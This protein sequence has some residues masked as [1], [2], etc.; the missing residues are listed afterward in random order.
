M[1]HISKAVLSALALQ[2]LLAACASGPRGS[3]FDPTEATKNSVPL[4]R[5]LIPAIGVVGLLVEEHEERAR[6]DR[7]VHTDRAALSSLIAPF[8]EGLREGATALR[9]STVETSPIQVDCA[10][11][12]PNDLTDPSD[13]P[14]RLPKR[15]S[16]EASTAESDLRGLTHLLL[17]VGWI[18]RT[19]G[20]RSTTWGIGPGI[21]AVTSETD[22]AVYVKVVARLYDLRTGV[23]LTE[24][25]AIDG[26]GGSYGVMLTLLP[27][28]AGPSQAS[29]LQA[30]SHAVGLEIGRRWLV[31]DSRFPRDTGRQ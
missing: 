21:P 3:Y 24:A 8:S 14:C 15:L 17:T 28:Y 19:T 6:H 23:A 13:A 1:Q 7:L 12:D 16:I 2:C 29:L 20:E 18:A 11:P 31:P 10:L 30:V 27:F 5:E 22:F 25:T 26:G 4:P 9:F